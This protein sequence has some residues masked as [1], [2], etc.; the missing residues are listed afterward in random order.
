MI[1]RAGSVA[2]ERGLARLKD[3]AAALNL[4]VTTISRALNGYPEVSEVTRRLVQETAE[5]LNYRPNP[6]AQKLVSG[7]SGMIGLITRRPASTVVD[8]SFMEVAMGLSSHLAN[9]DLDLVLR[10]GLEDDEVEPYRRMLARRS[11]DAFILNAPVVDDIRIAYLREKGATFVVHGRDRDDAD[12]PFYDMNNRKAS[13]DAVRLLADLGH[14]RI[15]L[16][17]GAQGMAFAAE[18][19]AGFQMALAERGLTVPPEQ[20]HHGAQEDAYGYVTTLALMSGRFGPAPTA[21]LCASTRI[22]EGVLRALTDRGLSVPGDVSVVAHDDAMP[23]L[24]PV[25]LP[26]SLTVTRLPFRDACKP[27]AEMVVGALA[28]QPAQSLQMTVDAE[29]IV[30]GSTAP[31]RGG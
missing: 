26:V 11:L 19:L 6:I 14:R 30:R 17:N 7:R 15:A 27:L 8:L 3:I 1:R 24:R 21:V 29:L 5:R 28:G 18:R 20:I 23:E 25:E 2:K 16:L 9:H 13:M 10:V 22:A 4:S 31:V 12:Y